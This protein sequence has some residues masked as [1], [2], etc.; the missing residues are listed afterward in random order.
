MRLY[1]TGDTHRDFRR[2]SPERFPEGQT[3]SREDCV[4]I[5]GDFGGVWEGDGKDDAVLD[6]LE[7]LPFT[8]LFIDGNH[9][10]FDELYALPTETWNGGLVRFVR[11]HVLHLARGQVFS[12]GGKT[13]FTMGG[14][15]SHDLWDGLLD[16][17]EPGFVERFW[18]LQSRRA[19]F[20]V[21]HMNWW[22]QEL[23]SEEEYAEARENLNRAGRKVD[24]IVT[25]CAPDSVQDQMAGGRFQ[26]DRL[27]G[28]LQEVR[29]TTEFRSWYF[30]HF[31]GSAAFPGGFRLLYHEILQVI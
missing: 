16:P 24:F 9:E 26:K 4:L 29:E 20:R 25:H 21:K 1:L 31:H 28:F 10:N 27:T 2:L 3:L 30:G 22:E 5:C 13:L 15:K 6:G 18:E 8:T 7:A 14:A 23:P 19:V 17:E 11:P 12:L